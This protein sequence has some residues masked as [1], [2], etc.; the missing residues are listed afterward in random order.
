MLSIISP[1]NGSSY[2]EEEAKRSSYRS[3]QRVVIMEFILE[4][5]RF[6]EVDREELN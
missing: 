2:Y 3:R 1:Q 5:D 6:R 4:E